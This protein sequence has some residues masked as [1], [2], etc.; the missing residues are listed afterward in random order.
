MTYD[1]IA[2]RV[3]C[4]REMC[5]RVT[6]RTLSAHL[7]QMPLVDT[8]YSTICVRLVGP[9]SPPS[10]GHRFILTVIDLCT[11]FP[12]A[13]PLKDIHTSAVPEALIGILSRVGI[14]RR[15][16]SDRGSRLTSEMMS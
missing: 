6:L 10:E 11:R 5:P 12:D 4:V 9:L 2:G 16:H 15:I 14:P 1:H 7:A 3:M 8:Q 13:V